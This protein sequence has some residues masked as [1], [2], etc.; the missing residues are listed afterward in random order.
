[1]LVD[2]TLRFFVFLREFDFGGHLRN[3][4]GW[5]HSKH[6]SKI[7]AI[8]LVDFLI[9][10]EFRR[11]GLFLLIHTESTN[12]TSTRP[13]Y[14]TLTYFR[15]STV[16]RNLICGIL[17][18][19]WYCRKRHFCNSGRIPSNSDMCMFISH[20]GMCMCVVYWSGSIVCHQY[21]LQGGIKTI[22]LSVLINHH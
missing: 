20:P 15:P 17:H 19:K 5:W 1:M 10:D 7:D 6:Y 21:F 2:A 8:S 12:V 3:Q 11:F 22:L 16:L 18:W 4:L 9:S 13:W 14:V